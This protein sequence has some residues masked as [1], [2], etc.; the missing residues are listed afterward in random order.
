MAGFN[1]SSFFG[2]S[3]SNG[4]GSIN[5][6]DYSLIKS[7]SY[8]KLMKSYYSPAKEE[9]VS[10]NDKTT[11]KK[12]TKDTDT[13]GLTKMKSEADELKK[14]TESFDKDVFKAGS[15]DKDKLVSTVKKFASEYNDVLT[16]S[17]KVTSKDVVVQTGYMISM[18][19]TMSNSL[20]KVGVA[21][22]ADG[23]LSVDEDTLK[24]AD[25]K[26]VKALFSGS[27]SYVSQIE[28]KASAISSA[29][30]RSSSMYSSDGELSSTMSG[31][32]NKWI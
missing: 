17:S 19:K 5:F 20:S 4:F 11:K 18:T 13:T 14:T 16:Q 32:F 30:F 2:N 23:K 29:A 10:K 21:V 15:E 27:Y 1:F 7:G 28:Q 9:K 25:T 12:D 22:A 24:N 3:N 31:M 26:D 6:A 8:K